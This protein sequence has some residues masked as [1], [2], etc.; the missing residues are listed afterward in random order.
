MFEYLYYLFFL[1]FNFSLTTKKFPS[2][3]RFFNIYLFVCFT[4]GVYREED[5]A[6]DFTPLEKK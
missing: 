6:I 5:R 4:G 2:H 3:V 1:G